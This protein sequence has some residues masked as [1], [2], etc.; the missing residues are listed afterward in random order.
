MTKTNITETANSGRFP[1]AK[2]QQ[3]NIQ[4]KELIVEAIIAECQHEQTEPGVDRVM[5][6]WRGKL[7]Q[8]PTA[9][10]PFQVDQIMRAARSRLSPISIVPSWVEAA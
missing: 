8:G 4:N 3:M 9:L 5:R 1:N 7:M 2:E 6:Q 10:E